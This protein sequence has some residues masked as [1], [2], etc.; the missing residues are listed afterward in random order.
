M[1][2]LLDNGADVNGT[3]G[4]LQSTPLQWAVWH[5][6]VDVVR[7]LLNRGA[8][9]DHMNMLG[10]NTTF[11]CWPTL[12]HGE[13]CKLDFL[14]LLAEDSYQDL[15]V[16]D[17]EG[18]TV[19]HRV[20]AF[21][22]PSEVLELIKLGANPDQ[23]ALPLR[24]NAVHHSVFYGN[25][26]TFEV[27]IPYYGEDLVSM[28]DER[29]WTLLHIAA[30]AGHDEIVQHLLRLGADPV[31]RTRP[32]MSHMPEVLFKRACTPQEVAAAQSPEREKQYLEAV[33]HLSLLGEY[34][35]VPIDHDSKDN[36]EF[37]EASEYA[38]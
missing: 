23:V 6:Q 16:A 33:H 4:L 12:Q 25:H 20:A 27:L 11:F 1:T 17:T 19:L 13:E 37:C 31:A 3:I 10:W 32:F 2:E 21:G 7:L 14:R 22:M 29:G 35:V 9:Q 30:S 34:V 15:D 8:S 28:T 38:W 26:G 36:L 18:W 5:K 24:W